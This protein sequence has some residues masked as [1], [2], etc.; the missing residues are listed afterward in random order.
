[1]SLLFSA[2]FTFFFFMLFIFS[3]RA[4]FI[5][6]LL[7]PF[8]LTKNSIVSVSL[9]F[10][11]FFSFYFAFFLL[12]FSI[13]LRFAF[14]C[15]LLIFC[16]I[17]LLKRQRKSLS[18]IFRHQRA[19]CFNLHLFSLA[20]FVLYDSFRFLLFLEL[21]SSLDV[22]RKFLFI[23]LFIWLQRFLRHKR[24]HKFNGHYS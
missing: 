24:M 7:I 1:M 22:F 16:F 13:L 23:G 21:F 18:L 11:L 14:W 10:L 20:C 19:Y 15:S 2:I 9:L 3:R 12:F 6:I 5:R 17:L 8:Q 4:F